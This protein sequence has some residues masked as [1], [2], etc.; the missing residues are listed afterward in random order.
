PAP[1][2]IGDAYLAQGVL[3]LR[4][5]DDFCASTEVLADSAWTYP[6]CAIS[7]TQIMVPAPGANDDI[8]VEFFDACGLRTAASMVSIANDAQ[9]DP[10]ISIN[11]FDINGAALG[12]SVAIGP[13]TVAQVIAPGIWTAKI[14]A[15][16]GGGLLGVDDFVFERPDRGALMGDL[17]CDGHV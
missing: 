12:T 5:N 8:V 3:F 2:P 17:N 9:A 13:G 14:C 10:S 16:A 6:C 11:A 4:G 7:G 15:V 1:A